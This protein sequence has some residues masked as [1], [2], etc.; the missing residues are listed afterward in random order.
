MLSNFWSSTGKEQDMKSE[1]INSRKLDEVV[2]EKAVLEEFEVEH[3][4]TCE[5]C[6]ELVRLFV[7]QNL[8]NNVRK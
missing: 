4:K 7:R 6:M 1:H 2:A 5:K 8:S 3:L